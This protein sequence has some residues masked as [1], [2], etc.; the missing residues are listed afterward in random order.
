M[1]LRALLFGLALAGGGL[2]LDTPTAWAQ[3]T[4]SVT[5]TVT[6][7]QTGQPI[8]GAQIHLVNTRYGGVTDQSG[9]FNITNVPAGTTRCRQPIS[10]TARA[11]CLT[12]WSGPGKPPRM[13]S[14][15][16]KPS[17]RAQ[18]VVSGSTNPTEGIKLPYT[19]TWSAR[20]SCKCD[21][22]L[23][24]PSIQGKVAE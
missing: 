14:R 2:L 21:Y 16:R 8:T 6:N 13:T 4:G 19:G 15:F 3:A 18:L 11:G 10:A 20:S 22:E 12:L 17:C 5:G 23:G 7:R 24:D 1:R 9:R